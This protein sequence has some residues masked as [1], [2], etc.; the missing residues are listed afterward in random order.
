MQRRPQR[1]MGA[2]DL[3][4]TTRVS[5]FLALSDFEWGVSDRD[6]EVASSGRMLSS[7]WS[8]LREIFSA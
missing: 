8:W 2:D 3:V 6:S 4:K 1:S 7:H 5:H